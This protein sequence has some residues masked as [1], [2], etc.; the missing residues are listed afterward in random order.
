MILS[1]LVMSNVYPVFQVG[2]CS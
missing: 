2:H 1:N